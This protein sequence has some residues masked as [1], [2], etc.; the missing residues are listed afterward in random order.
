MLLGFSHVPLVR[1][2]GFL[3]WFITEILDPRYIE[4][5][6]ISESNVTHNVLSLVAFSLNACELIFEEL[7][8]RSGLKWWIILYK[9]IPTDHFPAELGVAHTF[10]CFRWK[11]TND[12]DPMLS[13]HSIVNIIHMVM[14]LNSGSN[15]S[16]SSREYMRMRMSSIYLVKIAHR[17]QVSSARCSRWCM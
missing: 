14:I 6:C 13:F 12:N 15:L 1:P 3:S 7:Y 5:Q 10:F 11:S 16:D 4:L 8:C 17:G 9:N 2:R